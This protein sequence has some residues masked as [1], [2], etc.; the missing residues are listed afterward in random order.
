MASKRFGIVVGVSKFGPTESIAPL[1]Y[2][3]N[4]AV[5]VYKLLHEFCDF[6]EDQLKLFVSD[7]PE[8]S[9]QEPTR[10]NILEA[11]SYFGRTAEEDDLIL[12]FIASHGVEVSGSPYLL[13]CDTKMEVLRETA[14]DVN[15][16]NNVLKESKAKCVVRMFDACRAAYGGARSPGSSGMS[17]VFSRSLALKASG[18]ATISSCSSGELSYED[19]EFEQGVFSYYLCEGLSG[20]ALGESGDVTIYSLVTYIKTSLSNW[21]DRQTLTQTPNFSADLSGDLIFTSPEIKAVPPQLDTEHPLAEMHQSIRSSLASLDSDMRT[22]R[23]TSSE[24]LRALFRDANSMLEQLL[25]S[26]L[27]LHV[28]D[29]AV[30]PKL[31]SGSMDHTK[32]VAG[33]SSDFVET[34]AGLQYNFASKEL[35]VPESELV[36]VAIRFTFCYWL[37]YNHYCVI[38]QQLSKAYGDPPM[39]KKGYVKL[40]TLATNDQVLEAVREVLSRSG[41]A[42]GRWSASIKDCVET[43]ARP[44]LDK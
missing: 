9:G 20:G 11:L 14:L 16:V 19:P 44:H 5:R 37:W 1:K 40:P 18:W 26:D 38:P 13:T 31:F 34:S 4:D 3:K 32:R 7:P 28:S 39:V 27:I 6:K 22:L 33:V 17:D 15:M 24:E 23:F 43:T 30:D 35:I 42:I 25:T 12:I 21:S 36:I 29:E 10:G 8:G 41:E 2:T